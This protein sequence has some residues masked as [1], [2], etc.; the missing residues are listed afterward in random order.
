MAPSGDRS[1]SDSGQIHPVQ[2]PKDIDADDGL[3]TLKEVEAAG[4]Q[5]DESSSKTI[6]LRADMVVMPVEWSLALQQRQY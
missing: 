5:L 1:A 6:R 2:A 4:L 3:Q